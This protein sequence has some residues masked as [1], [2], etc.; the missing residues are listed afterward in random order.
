MRSSEDPD[1]ERL[2][3]D[4]GAIHRICSYRHPPLHPEVKRIRDDVIA[5][6]TSRW[7][8]AHKR[9]SDD[10]DAINRMCSSEA[11]LS[12]ISILKFNASGAMIQ[13]SYQIELQGL[14]RS[15]R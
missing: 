10:N 4:D 11:R 13:R 7:D 6:M 14:R 2:A 3:D 15:D 5:N 9:L 8:S 1:I 12:S